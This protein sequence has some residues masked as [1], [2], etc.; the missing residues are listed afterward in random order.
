MCCGFVLQILVNSTL[1]SSMTFTKTSQKFGQWSDAK[2]NTVYGLG[3]SSEDELLKVITDLLK[4]RLSW[5]FFFCWLCCLQCV[6]TVV[7]VR[8][9]VSI[10]SPIKKLTSSTPSVFWC[11][12][13]VQEIEL[14]CWEEGHP[15][16]KKLVSTPV[17]I[18]RAIGKVSVEAI[19]CVC[20]L[21]LLSVM[22][23][24]FD[25]GIQP[26]L[27]NSANLQAPEVDGQLHS[28]VKTKN[29]NKK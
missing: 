4:I 21:C 18:E 26:S 28:T 17:I 3:F 6:D 11:C 10:L 5:C 24:Y 15:G 29:T 8:W 2:A 14:S 20:V 13:N 22:W 25:V 27:R 23:Y 12:W 1:T 9:L 16:H 7:G 19:V